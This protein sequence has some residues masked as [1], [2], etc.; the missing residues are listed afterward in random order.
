[1]VQSSPYSASMPLAPWESPAVVAEA[2]ESL[3]CQTLPPDQVVVS[4][5]GTPPAP[6]LCCLE[7]AD[8]PIMLL[9]PG[10][11]GVGPVLARGLLHCREEPALR[12]DADDLSL[13]ERAARQV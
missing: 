1:M 2:L 7:A 10:S 8:M 13:P 5:D 3:R 12:V 4:C 11:E 6:L 9:G